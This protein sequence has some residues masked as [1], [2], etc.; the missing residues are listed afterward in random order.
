MTRRLF[1]LAPERAWHLFWM[2]TETHWRA[3]SLEHEGFLHL[4][5]AEQLPGTLEAHFDGASGLR[6]VEI[7]ATAVENH[8]RLEVSRGGQDFPHLY[9]PLP[10]D[11]V[12]GTWELEYRG[13]GW[14]LPPL[15]EA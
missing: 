12:L 4:S 14:L 2:G 5:F 7:D 15:S 6:L 3:P 9:A 8:L 13:S 10:R 1:H 11:A